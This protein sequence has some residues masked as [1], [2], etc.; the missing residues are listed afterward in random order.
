MSNNYTTILIALAAIVYILYA[1]YREKPVKGRSY[2]IA[3]IIFIFIGYNDLENLHG[4]LNNYILVLAGL[5]IL[6]LIIGMI[7][8]FF[9]KFYRKEDGILYQK[10]GIISAIFILLGLSLREV[11][12]FS[13]M[14]TSY[15]LLTKG[16]LLIVLLLGFQYA[17][18]SLIAIYREPSIINQLKSTRHNK[19]R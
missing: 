12:R 10:G 5:C 7:S 6:F 17:G 13:L 18:R 11:F 9:I 14:H 4:N 16:A 15:A 3:P 1:Q 2:I 19:R 8:G